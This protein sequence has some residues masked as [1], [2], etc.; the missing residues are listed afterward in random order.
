MLA[1]ETD[2]EV[3]TVP[4]RSLGCAGSGPAGMDQECREGTH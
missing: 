2:L 3:E 1:D 4:S